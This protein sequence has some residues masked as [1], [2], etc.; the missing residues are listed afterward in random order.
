[1]VDPGIFHQIEGYMLHFIPQDSFQNVPG[2]LQ[3]APRIFSYS[4][5]SQFALP[6]FFFFLIYIFGVGSDQ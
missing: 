2:L 3:N 1:M 6:K 4:C 5:K